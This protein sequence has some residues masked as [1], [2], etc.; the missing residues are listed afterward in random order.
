MTKQRIDRWIK[1][2]GTALVDFY[3]LSGWIIKYHYGPDPLA[4]EGKIK[5]WKTQATVDRMP[6]YQRA[7]IC[8]VPESIENE[9]ELQNVLGHELRH[10][11]CAHYIQFYRAVRELNFS[12]QALSM[13]DRIWHIAEEESV[14]ALN[15]MSEGHQR[16]KNQGKIV[17]APAKVKHARQ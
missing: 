2:N 1:K 5:N 15:R 9:D 7:Q 12:K 17:K 11:V 3:G 10:I 13:L 4:F 6:E 8:L 14:L 16:W